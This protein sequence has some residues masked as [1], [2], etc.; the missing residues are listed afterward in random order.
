LTNMQA[1]LRRAQTNLGYCT[2]KSPVDGIIIDRRV[3]VGQTVVSSLNT[4]SLFLIAKDLKRMQVWASVNEADIGQIHSGQ[5]V[6]FTVDAYPNQPFEGVVAPDQPRL[7]ASMN[8]NVVTYTVVVNTDN[9]NGKLLPYLTAD[10]QFEVARHEKVL[11]VPNAALRWRPSPERLAAS[12][13]PAMPAETIN[14]AAKHVEQPE[15]DGTSS[16]EGTLWVADGQKVRPL[17]VRTGLSD[18][19]HTEVAASD[20][21][22][23]AP[24]VIGEEFVA[25]GSETSNPFSPK[26]FGGGGSRPQ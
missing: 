18:G 19:T 13:L 20:L 5:S 14:A 25:G 4:P 22:E 12:G 17:K 7:N 1:N 2:I 6:R 21:P 10:L 8:Q 9:S 23:G 16:G 11:Y 26:V 15:P 24:I 3:N